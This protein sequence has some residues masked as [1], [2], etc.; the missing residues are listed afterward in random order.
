MNATLSENLN[1]PRWLTYLRAA[2]FSVPAIVAW[3]FAS[4][5]LVPKA[6]E[7]VGDVSLDTSRFG[8]LWPATM[9]LV[10]WGQTLLLLGILAFIVLEF[11]LPA[12]RRRRRL[13][14]EIAIWLVN[15]AVVFGLA[16]LFMIV[17]I[18]APGVARGQ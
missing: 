11:A 3:G 1:E 4:I 15:A 12:W 14:V 6:R 8:V 7:L 16:I 5:F 2:I 13:L 17:V 18:A 9:F 10:Q